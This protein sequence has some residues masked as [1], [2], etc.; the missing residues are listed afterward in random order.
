MRSRGSTARRAIIR[1]SRAAIARRWAL[2]RIASR[3]AKT[4]RCAIGLIHPVLQPVCSAPPIGRSPSACFPARTAPFP[5]VNRRRIR[6]LSSAWCATQASRRDA[7]APS[8]HVLAT[9]LR[10]A[11]TA[12]APRT[13]VS[14]G[15]PY[16]SRHACRSAPYTDP[17]PR[18]QIAPTNPT[19][20]IVAARSHREREQKKKKRAVR[21]QEHFVL[22]P[23]HAFYRDVAASYHKSAGAN[24]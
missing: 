19:T 6:R 13:E 7:N 17:A 11:R 23:T 20:S 16:S 12:A 15:A 4:R 9:S 14:H 5:R 3:A 24:T 1:G 21:R 8:R 2:L 22:P 10:A 18:R